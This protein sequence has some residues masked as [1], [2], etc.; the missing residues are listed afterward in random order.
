MQAKTDSAETIKPES[1]PWGFWKTI[2][3]SLIISIAYLLA[4]IVF[5]FIYLFISKFLRPEINIYEYSRSLDSN[6][7]YLALSTLFAAP[8]MIGLVIFFSYFCKGIP[9]RQYLCVYKPSLKELFKWL[10]IQLL[11]IVGSD[12]LTVLMG[13]SVVPD[14]M[15]NVYETAL[16]TP[17]LWFAFIIAA[18]LGE[19]IFFRGFLFKGIEDSKIGSIGAIFISAVFWSIIH[20]QYDL[21][22]ISCIFVGGLILGLARAKSKSIYVPIAMHGLMNLVASIEVALL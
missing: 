16:F 17:L 14:W 3:F 4:I 2:G 15:V 10:F 5:T 22:G 20:I 12:T 7:F 9:V 11:F 19:E 6:G 18:P 13:R 21:Y 8:L 1:K